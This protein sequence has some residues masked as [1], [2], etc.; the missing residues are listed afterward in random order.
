MLLDGAES[1]DRLNRARDRSSS[2][3]AYAHGTHN[4]GQQLHRADERLARRTEDL[5]T[6]SGRAA[7]A[8][9]AAFRDWEQPTE[10]GFDDL[11]GIHQPM[12]V[13]ADNHDEMIAVS[14]SYR[15]AENSPNAVLLAY[16]I[17][18]TCRGPVP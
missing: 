4:E 13:V 2:E 6:A 7:A 18:D 9:V 14:T 3:R 17:R 10:T 5:D 15:L 8:Q 11:G 16:Q 1:P 12:L